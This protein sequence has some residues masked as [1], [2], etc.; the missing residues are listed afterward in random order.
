MSLPKD[1]PVADICNRPKVCS[2][3]VLT[4]DICR[5]DCYQEIR[6]SILVNCSLKDTV[7][8]YAVP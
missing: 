1:E 3:Q 7:S 5:I 2:Q 8:A 6:G 4:L